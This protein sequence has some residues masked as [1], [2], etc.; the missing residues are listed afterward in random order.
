MLEFVIEWDSSRWRDKN[1]QFFVAAEN[2]EKCHSA[3]LNV[4]R[5][6]GEQLCILKKTYPGNI[7]DENWQNHLYVFNKEVWADKLSSITVEGSGWF[8]DPPIIEHFTAL[9][10]CETNWALYDCD[11]DSR[12]IYTSTV[13]KSRMIRRKYTLDSVLPM[14]EESVS[15]DGKTI[16]YKY[17]EEVA[18]LVVFLEL[19]ED[20]PLVNKNIK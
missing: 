12:E 9:A 13:E 3:L 17:V 2:Y 18:I 10:D 15:E 6:N 19:E 1:I 11:W 20:L 5:N 16:K 7:H 14:H 4:L 8:W